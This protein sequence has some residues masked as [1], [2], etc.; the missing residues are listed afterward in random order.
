MP[1][2]TVVVKDD[3]N[4][5]ISLDVDSRDRVQD[6]RSLV[7]QKMKLPKDVRLLFSGRLLRN[8]IVLDQAGVQ[9]QST[10]HILRPADQLGPGVSNVSDMPENLAQLQ[11]HLLLNPDIMQQMMNSPAMQ[12]LLNDM[13]FLKNILSMNTKVRHLMGPNS[14][15]HKMFD[16]PSF[17]QQALDAFRNP[18]MMR[19]LLRSTDSAMGCLNQIPGGGSGVIHKLYE[20]LG[21]R[22]REDAPETPTKTQREFDTNAMAAMMQDPNLQQLLAQSFAM[23]DEESPLSNAQVLAQLFRPANMFAVAA[24]EESIAS[25]ALGKASK[26][27][28]APAPHFG[29]TFQVFMQAQKENPELQ[30][31]TQLQ[32]LR[33][34]GF[35][36][37]DQCI[38][39]L[40]ASGGAVQA[41]ID[42]ML[43]D[44][45]A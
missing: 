36:D 24:M 45:R 11:N 27:S 4:A 16:D 23:A 20:G 37:T 22:T 40:I 2:I 21:G 26:E 35:T 42:K 10:L 14:E 31:R 19:D 17:T 44:A 15:L 7:A 6:V 1:A 8:E 34:M 38:Q 25:M 32:N 5:S 30:Y 43:A 9:H 3:A 28:G 29:S 41:A 39:A 33:N 18:S 12:S 13:R